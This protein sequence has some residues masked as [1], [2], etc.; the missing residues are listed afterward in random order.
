MPSDLNPPTYTVIEAAQYMCMPELT[1]VQMKQEELPS[2]DDL[3]FRAMRDVLLAAIAEGELS[4]VRGVVITGNRKREVPLGILAHDE[5]KRWLAVRWPDFR[6]NVWFQ[7]EDPVATLRDWLI[8]TEVVRRLCGDEKQPR[9]TTK[10]LLESIP[11]KYSLKRTASA[12]IYKFIKQMLSDPT[13]KFLKDGKAKVN[14][15]EPLSDGRCSTISVMLHTLLVE[16][17]WASLDDALAAYIS[18]LSGDIGFVSRAK[19]SGI[20]KEMPKALERKLV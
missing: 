12:K 3:Q 5:I 4:Y 9:N 20:F 13:L 10:H 6:P 1:F 17:G 8:V 7:V 11:K 15:E 16:A 19:V 14:I 2:E 18:E